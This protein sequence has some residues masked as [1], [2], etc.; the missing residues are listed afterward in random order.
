M[1]KVYVDLS[2]QQ[3]ALTKAA[4]SQ[5]AGSH[6]QEGKNGFSQSSDSNPFTD[7]VSL[8]GI[9][10]NSLNFRN[11]ALFPPSKDRTR[12]A[13]PQGQRARHT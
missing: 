3:I 8:P 11:K 10:R 7:A 4:S 9:S 1:N 2:K 6:L 5:S 13:I 12:P